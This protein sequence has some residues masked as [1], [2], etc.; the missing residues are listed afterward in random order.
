MIPVAIIRISATQGA[1]PHTVSLDGR[2]SADPEGKRLKY[3]WEI[4]SVAVSKEPFFVHVF[5]DIGTYHVQLIVEDPAG[6]KATSVIFIE[7]TAPEKV[8]SIKKALKYYQYEIGWLG[9]NIKSFKYY[10]IKRINVSEDVN[11]H[12]V[13]DYGEGV[14]HY[15]IF[16]LGRKLH[17]IWIDGDG[18]G[19]EKIIFSEDFS[20]AKGWWNYDHSP[21]Q[22]YEIRLRRIK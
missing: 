10:K 21:K 7:V 22:K 17:G 11:C 5:E 18:S 20:S 19:E 3:A 6:A 8:K 14:A 1:A 4:N 15:I 12:I 2:T 9:P 13:Y 16:E